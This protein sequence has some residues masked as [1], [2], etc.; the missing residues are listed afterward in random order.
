MFVKNYKKSRGVNIYDYINLH[1]YI[2]QYRYIYR[3][4]GSP[5]KVM[6]FLNT[7]NLF[8]FLDRKFV[9]NLH[10]IQLFLNGTV[11]EEL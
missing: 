2:V 6:N 1:C 11:S 5:T 7:K 8:F 3:F 4:Q 9:D 10:V